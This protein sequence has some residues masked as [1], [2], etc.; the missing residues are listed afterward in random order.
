MSVKVLKERARKYANMQISEL[1]RESLRMSVKVLKERGRKYANMQ[2]SKLFRESLRMSVKV[3][4]EERKGDS[5]PGP[6]L[7]S[8]P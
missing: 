4:K 8:P 7:K 5:D 1:L 3:H 6:A 2:I